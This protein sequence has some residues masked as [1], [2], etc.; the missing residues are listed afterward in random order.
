MD[1]R[2]QNICTVAL[3]EF[4]EVEIQS[5]DGEAAGGVSDAFRK[6]LRAELGNHSSGEFKDLDAS[7]EV[8]L[9]MLDAAQKNKEG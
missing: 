7:F 6:A 3:N 8:S 1:E 9:R 4:G 5:W 2:T